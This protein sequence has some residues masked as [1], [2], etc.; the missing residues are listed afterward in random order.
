[1]GGGVTNKY[2]AEEGF[3]SQS[4]IRKGSLD[5]TVIIGLKK[6]GMGAVL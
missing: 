4:E 3:L 1:V 6:H 5:K 2:P